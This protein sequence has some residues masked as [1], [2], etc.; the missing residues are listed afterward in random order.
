MPSRRLLLYSLTIFILG[1]A[2]AMRI[3]WLSPEQILPKNQYIKII[4][5]VKREP[6]ISGLRQVLQI[7]DGRIYVNLYPRYKVGD[8]L[9]IT[10][11]IDSVGRI[12]NA[13]VEKVGEGQEVGF[14]AAG[15]WMG[16]LR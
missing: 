2:V 8:R 3:I 7:G 16:R 13:K 15:K 11:E 4:A 5:T 6:R 10:G 14:F 9:S 12:F 1:L